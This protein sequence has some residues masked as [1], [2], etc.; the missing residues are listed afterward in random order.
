M[1]RLSFLFLSVSLVLAV[2][3]SPAPP[4]ET[5]PPTLSVPVS[6]PLERKVIDYAEFTGRTTAIESVRVRARVWGHLE[7]INFVEGAEVKKGDLLFVIDQRPYRAA[8]ER[9][10]ADVAA[11]EAALRPAGR[12]TGTSQGACFLSL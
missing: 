2:G 3:C 6:R 9:A 12:R 1:T 10:E 4:A 7:K 5:A 11:G 8:L